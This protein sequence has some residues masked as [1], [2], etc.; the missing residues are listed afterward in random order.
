[1]VNKFEQ[2]N[3]PNIYG[4]GDVLQ[5]KPELTPLAIQTGKLLSRRLYQG[6][7]E[8][9]DYEMIPTTVFT[10]LEYGSIGYSEEDAVAKFGETNIEVYH[11]YFKPLEWTVPHREDNACFA[12]LVC[13]K[14]ENDRVIGLH[15]LGPNA[16]EVTQG[17]AVA[18]RMRATRTDF[19]ATIG[20]HPTTSEEIIKLRISKSSGA[21][22]KTTG[23]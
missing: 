20:I 6:S 4:V 15:Y 2:T 3:V 21:D 7:K 5:A 14:T 22:A 11:S 9:T 18:M 8:L 1:I 13:L 12:K 16:G 10:P 19:A 17:Y 23:C